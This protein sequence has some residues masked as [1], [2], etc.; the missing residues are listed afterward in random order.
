LLLTPI[1][2]TEV[3]D[4]DRQGIDMILPRASRHSSAGGCGI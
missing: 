3:K 4:S 2:A 1:A